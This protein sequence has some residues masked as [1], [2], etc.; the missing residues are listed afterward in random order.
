M[1]NDFWLQICL[2]W[3]DN[4]SCISFSSLSVCRVSASNCASIYH[5]KHEDVQLPPAWKF[6]DALTDKHVNKGFKVLSLLEHIRY[7][8]DILSVPHTAKHGR[9]FDAVMEERN[10]AI[11]MDG[12]PE[13]RHTCD[14]CTRRFHDTET[15]TGTHIVILGVCNDS[16][17]FFR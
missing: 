5:A 10:R 3:C 17:R 1:L 15:S 12:Q 4:I 9:R 14:G 7:S 2:G 8:N 11:K 6:G 13:L 16:L